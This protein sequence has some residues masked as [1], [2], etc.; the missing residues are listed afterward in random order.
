[1]ILAHTDA[2][3]AGESAVTTENATDAVLMKLVRAGV[4]Y[5]PHTHV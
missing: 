3:Y 4:R 1:M 2:V 5:M